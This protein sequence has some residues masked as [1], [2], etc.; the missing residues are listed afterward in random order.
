MSALLASSPS[1]AE[2]WRSRDS[3]AGRASSVPAA[4]R[5]ARRSDAR[6][7]ASMRLARSTSSVAVSSRT[8]PISRRYM[9]TGIGRAAARL[10]GPAVAHAG[11]AAHGGRDAAA[12]QVVDGEGVV[13]GAAT[14]GA[15]AARGD[16]PAEE[17]GGR[18]WFDRALAW[19]GVDHVDL[20]NLDAGLGAAA[21]DHRQHLRRELDA[22]ECA[23]EVFL[24]HSSSSR[25]LLDQSGQWTFDPAHPG[26]ER[27][28]LLSHPPSPTRCRSQASNRSAEA[29]AVSG[30]PP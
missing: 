9:R 2:R 23:D 14:D 16:R 19:T 20:L 1:S 24:G 15:Q 4:S 30:S 8:R 11:L 3:A 22:W 26:V 17:Q 12:P 5:S 21:H 13:G 27:R 28:W 6:A 7:P 10:V 25:G 18:A 29:V